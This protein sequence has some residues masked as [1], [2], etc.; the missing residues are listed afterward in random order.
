ME[1]LDL[2]FIR[3]HSKRILAASPVRY[4]RTARLRGTLFGEDDDPT[5]VS[6][7]DTQYFVDHAEPR[8][9]LEQWKAK[10]SGSEWPLGR[11]LQGH[12]YFVVVPLGAR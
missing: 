4:I 8:A 1:H 2:A 10:M 12:E 7:A 3:Q 6:L 5:V 11:L 9:A